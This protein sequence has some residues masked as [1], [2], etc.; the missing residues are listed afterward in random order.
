MKE[1]HLHDSLCLNFN[2]AP[3]WSK[4]TMTTSQFSGPLTLLFNDSRLI[5]VSTA[6][7]H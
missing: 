4:Q 3:Y 2:L 7:L 5:Y 1:S 6:Q